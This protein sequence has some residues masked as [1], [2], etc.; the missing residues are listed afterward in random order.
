AVRTLGGQSMTTPIGP[1]PIGPTPTGPTPTGPTPSEPTATTPTPTGRGVQRGGTGRARGRA[2]PNEP[3][4]GRDRGSST[5]RTRDGRPNPG[6]SPSPNPAGT[7]SSAGP[8][9]EPTGLPAT[10]RPGDSTVEPDPEP[11]GDVTEKTWEPERRAGHRRGV[12]G[13]G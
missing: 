1:T 8:A 2:A 13:I 4:K 9:P 6:A 12:D 11:V 7:G 5:R 3:A 10:R